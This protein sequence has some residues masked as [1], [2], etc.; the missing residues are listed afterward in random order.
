MSLKLA[1]ITPVYKKNKSLDKT[2]W[3]G[4]EGMKKLWKTQNKSYLE[5]KEEEILNLLGRLS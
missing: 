3:R 5:W 2:N 1:D 4:L